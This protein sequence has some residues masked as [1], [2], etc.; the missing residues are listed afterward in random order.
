MRPKQFSFGSAL[1]AELMAVNCV[2]H[3]QDPHEL[4]ALLEVKLAALIGHRYGTRS[5]NAVRALWRP[6]S[7]RER[8]SSQRL[9]TTAHNPRHLRRPTLRV[10]KYATVD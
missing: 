6:M 5:I 3:R 4:L 2:T 9:G 1:N 10:R 7:I 8:N